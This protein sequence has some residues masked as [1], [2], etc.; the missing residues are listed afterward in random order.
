MSLK[1]FHI[2]FISIATLFCLGF[3]VWAVG[4][5]MNGGGMPSLAMAIVSLLFGVALPPYGIW[6]LRKLKSVSFL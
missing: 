4:D 5:Y 2:V 3:G 6:F 1:T